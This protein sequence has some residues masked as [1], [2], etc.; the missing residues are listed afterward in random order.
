MPE[1]RRVS[2]EG[3]DLVCELRDSGFVLLEESFELRDALGVHLVDTDTISN[4]FFCRE[5]GLRKDNML[6]DIF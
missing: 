5:A 1:G 3:V 2:T 6:S 4:R